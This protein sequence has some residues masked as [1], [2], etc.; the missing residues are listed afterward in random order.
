MKIIVIGECTLDIICPG[1]CN[2]AAT[3]RAFP[4]GRLLNAAAILGRQGHDVAYVGEAARDRVGDII[5]NFLDNHHVATRSID[6]FT[7]G[8]TSSNLYFP[9]DSTHPEPSVVSYRK[10]PPER[11]DVVWPRIDPDDIVVFGT[12]FALDER[13]RPQLQELMNH[14]QERKAT[15]IYVPGF[16]PEQ[17]PRITKVMPAIL[18]NLEMADI[19]LSRPSDLQHIFS[20]SDASRCFERHIRFY[21][22]DFINIDSPSGTV[23]WLHNNDHLQA[24]TSSSLVGSLM[25]HAGA[26]AGLIEGMEK[27]DLKKALIGSLNGP[28][29]TQL[30]QDMVRTADD[31]ASQASDNH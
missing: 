17:A 23:S 28:L 9:P 27:I 29:L 20:E 5:V 15:I 13:V 7:D 10:F 4:G 11:F 19:V 14:A 30:L 25:W 24:N 1:E 2:G 3:L 22:K 12:F 16:L 8:V 26:L 31:A 6:R 21:C 18:E